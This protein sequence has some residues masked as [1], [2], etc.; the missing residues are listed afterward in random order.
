MKIN[1]HCKKK[2]TVGSDVHTSEILEMGE[3]GENKSPGG[4]QCRYDVIPGAEIRG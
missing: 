2:E 3:R 1:A 4:W